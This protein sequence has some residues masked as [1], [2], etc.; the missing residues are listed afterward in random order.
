LSY[1][2]L[3]LISHVR[4]S[5]RSGASGKR[6]WDEIVAL[7]AEAA[8]V[9]VEFDELQQLG[10]YEASCSAWRVKADAAVDAC[11]WLNIICSSW[12]DNDDAEDNVNSDNDGIVSGEED[13]ASPPP[14]K[15]SSRDNPE[16]PCLIDFKE[17]FKS[18]WWIT[19]DIQAR[20]PL[21]RN[22]L[23]P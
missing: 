21:S 10:V 1:R 14:G 17:F 11:S 12:S 22:T 2:A 20:A 6:R 7:L 18:S 4:G 13:S 23:N 16:A 5:T 15:S 8:E 9:G 3:E 19:D